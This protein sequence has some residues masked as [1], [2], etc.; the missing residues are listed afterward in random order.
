MSMKSHLQHG[1]FA[2]CRLF[3]LLRRANVVI[4]QTF[5]FRYIGYNY[6]FISRPTEYLIKPFALQI[7]D[8]IFIYYKGCNRTHIC[9][10]F[11]H[12]RFMVKQS[13]KGRRV[14][15][16]GAEV[17]PC[18]EILEVDS[19]NLKAIACLAAEGVI[20]GILVNIDAGDSPGLSKGGP[21]QQDCLPGITYLKILV[22]FNQFCR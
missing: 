15:R 4:F 19:V 6:R 9:Q 20:T 21:G 13:P 17:K 16:A 11:I 8:V 10:Q 5:H 7:V 14:I 1:V 3:F 22:S 18:G 12:R 2:A